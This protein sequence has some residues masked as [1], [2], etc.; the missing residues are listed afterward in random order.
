M[1]GNVS[2]D[3]DVSAA[4]ATALE[5]N[6]AGIAVTLIAHFGKDAN[7]GTRGSVQW[8][9]DADQVRYYKGKPRDGNACIEL[10][11]VKLEGNDGTKIN[12]RYEKRQLAD[13]SV[14]HV[15]LRS[16]AAEQHKQDFKRAPNQHTRPRNVVLDILERAALRALKAYPAREFNRKHFVELLTDEPE[17]DL[18]AQTI[19]RHYLSDLLKDR[20]RQL[21]RFYDKAKRT[22]RYGSAAGK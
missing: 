22:L 18:E 4:L 20:D 5:L 11:K 2:D 13:G 19:T 21:H 7:L 14:G 9:A 12:V 17:V 15:I 8:E 3:K 10:E 16:E 6:E 1:V